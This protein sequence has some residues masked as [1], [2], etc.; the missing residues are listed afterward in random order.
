MRLLAEQVGASVQLDPPG[1]VVEVDERRLAVAAAG[2]DATGDAVGEIGLLAIG[3]VVV[4][5]V[6][7]LDRDDAR[8]LVWERL[9][10]IRP[11]LLELLAPVIHRRDPNPLRFL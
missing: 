2:M 6:D 11:Q 4:R 5:A 7:A 8:E 1:S 3:E 10:A 9:D